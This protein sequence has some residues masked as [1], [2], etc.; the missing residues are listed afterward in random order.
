LNFHIHL[1]L[2]CTS[3]ELCDGLAVENMPDD[4]LLTFGSDSCPHVFLGIS[5]GREF[6]T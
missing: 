5:G 2:P 4:V 6:L 3:F 1:L